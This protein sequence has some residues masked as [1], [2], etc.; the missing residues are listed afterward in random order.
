MGLLFELA[1]V[2]GAHLGADEESAP[3]CARSF[4]SLHAMRISVALHVASA[5][6]IVSAIR[7]DT[8]A[9]A[10]AAAADAA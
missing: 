4:R 10:R 1:R 8:A 6:E 3:W 5:D 7:I 9:A 2:H